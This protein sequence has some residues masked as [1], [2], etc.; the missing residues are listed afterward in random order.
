MTT[1]YKEIVDFDTKDSTF[2]NGNND[3]FDAIFTMNQPLKRVRHVTLKSLELINN[4]PNIRSGTNSLTFKT[5]SGSTTYTATLASANYT[6]IGALLTDLNTAC[7]GLVPGTSIAF[8]VNTTTNI[9]SCDVSGTLLDISSS[10]LASECLGFRSYTGSGT[11]ILVAKSCYTLAFDTYLYM[12]LRNIPVNRLTTW[13]SQKSFKLQLPSSWG[14]LQYLDEYTSYS[15][16]IDLV[17]TDFSLTTLQVQI[18]DRFNN[19]LLVNNANYSFSL[20]FEMER[21]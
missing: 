14:I 5:H 10:V 21:A 1:T 19:L 7:T 20:E 18:Y 11:G 13:R 17:D 8:T 15:Q 12:Y 9:V 16:T 3:C 6:S 4:I 2:A